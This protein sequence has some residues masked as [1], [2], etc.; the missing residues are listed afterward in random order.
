MPH[1]TIV[2][3]AFYWDSIP[4][5]FS[6][7]WHK[8]KQIVLTCKTEL[9]SCFRFFQTSFS[10]TRMSSSALKCAGSEAGLCDCDYA[11]QCPINPRSVPLP[12]KTKN[13]CTDFRIAPLKVFL[14]PWR[15]TLKFIPGSSLENQKTEWLLRH[16]FMYFNFL[17][18]AL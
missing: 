16:L 15:G 11:A 18:S 9:D 13:N 12:G 3:F 7:S 4:G 6:V 10:L 8:T 2:F 1:R 5:T 14:P 17:C